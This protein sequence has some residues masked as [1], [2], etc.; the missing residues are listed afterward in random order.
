MDWVAFIAAVIII[1]GVSYLALKV[2]RW[3]SGRTAVNRP[4]PRPYGRSSGSGSGSSGGG[5]GRD[6]GPGPVR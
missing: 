4:S 2:W 3:W 5:D 1:G 6:D